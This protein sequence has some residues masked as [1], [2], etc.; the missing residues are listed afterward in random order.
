MLHFTHK[1]L[2]ERKGCSVCFCCLRQRNQ[3]FE[4]AV[5]SSRSNAYALSLLERQAVLS[6][7]VRAHVVL[8]ALT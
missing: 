5:A 8:T 7:S 6:L 3:I 2:I 4:R 1:L